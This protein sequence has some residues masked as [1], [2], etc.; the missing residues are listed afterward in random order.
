M[1][2]GAKI[3]PRKLNLSNWAFLTNLSQM[4]KKITGLG[5]I[6]KRI[7]TQSHHLFIMAN[8]AKIGPRKLNLSNWAFLTNLFQIIKK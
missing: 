2:N 7:L 8:G 6:I 5:Q 1:A 4:I 3:G